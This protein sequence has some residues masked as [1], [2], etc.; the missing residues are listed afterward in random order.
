MD[1]KSRI[2]LFQGSITDLEVD[3]IVN[4]AN[5]TLLGGG[6]VDGAIHRG[7]GPKLLEECRMLG[8]CATGDAKLTKGYNLRAKYVIHAVGPI[9][10]GGGEHE[11]ELLESAYR[12]C[13]E[14]ADEYGIKSIAFPALSTGAYKYPLEPATRIALGTT[15]LALQGNENIQKVVFACFG[16]DVFA[17]Y[18]RLLTELPN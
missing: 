12:T 14:L 1:V 10:R 7:A 2:E 17:M 8:G 11:N 4:A 15:W 13:F 5:R 9:W 6:G 16:D 3:A 18:S